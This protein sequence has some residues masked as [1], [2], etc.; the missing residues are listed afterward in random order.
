M[1]YVIRLKYLVITI[2]FINSTNSLNILH[3]SDIHFNPFDECKINEINTCKKLNHLIN[4]SINSWNFNQE[5]PINDK[6]QETNNSFLNK[7]LSLCFNEKFESI[8]TILVTGDLLE[9]KFKYHFKYFK[10]FATKEMYTNFTIKTIHYVL[11][12]LH[13]QFPK[14]KIYFTL[15]NNDTDTEDYE[16]PSNLF[17]LNLKNVL[18]NYTD[19]INLQ[20][21]TN[22]GYFSAPID[23][24]YQIIALNTNTFTYKSTS[25]ENHVTSIKQL[26]WLNN[27][28]K[29]LSLQNKKIIIISHIPFGIDVHTT[30]KN[31]EI[32]N[33]IKS[34][35]QKQYLKILSKY[36]N[37]ILV[38]FSGH[39]HSNYTQQFDNIPIIGTIAFNTYFGN[40]AG[41]K[42]I[43]LN[44]QTNKINNINTII[45]KNNQC[46]NYP[47]VSNKISLNNYFKELI[48][49][50]EDITNTYKK[51]FIGNNN[52]QQYINNKAY[53][54]YYYCFINKFDKD[55]YQ[56]CINNYG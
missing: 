42:I 8:D 13:K 33:T 7:N 32:I 36:K 29:R 31:K 14:A 27:E 22:G 3:I 45:I 35:Y 34:K 46:L 20:E 24:K 28:I 30:I 53:W 17:L 6:N 26:D 47:I 43:K 2:F 11:E 40:N 9:H 4:H 5:S 1:N 25:K 18:T 23:N 10:P 55:T 37:N 56:E 19:Q 50:N 51:V 12:K 15:G 48:N 54:F 16:L 21:V 41:Y 38:I 52:K 49:N 44:E 39:F